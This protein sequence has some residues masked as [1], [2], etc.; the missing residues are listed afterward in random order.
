VPTGTANFT[1]VVSGLP[2]GSKTVAPPGVS[3]VAA[4]GKIVEVD[5]AIGDNSIAVPTG[6]TYAVI[7]FP[8]TLATVTLKNAGGDSGNTLFIG[9]TQALFMVLLVQ[10]ATALILNATILVSGVEVSFL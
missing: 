4:V 1:C 10:N 9:A 5:L 3:L 8:I 7:E 6:A 2:T